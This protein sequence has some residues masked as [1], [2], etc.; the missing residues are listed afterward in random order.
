ML[1]DKEL[2]IVAQAIKRERGDKDFQRRRL[3][4]VWIASNFHWY[5]AMDKAF[6]AGKRG[7]NQVELPQDSKQ[8]FSMIYLALE[9]LVIH[10]LDSKWDF[11]RINKAINST[12]EKS[13][14]VKNKYYLEVEEP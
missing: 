13:A 9:N 5:F 11:T 14:N 8:P 10:L 3:I 1:T 12:M 2:D 6:M 4:R 7:S